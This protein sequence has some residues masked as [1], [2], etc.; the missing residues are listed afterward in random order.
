MYHRIQ[1]VSAVLIF[2]LF[3]SGCSGNKKKPASR[4]VTADASLAGNYLLDST[5]LGR[6]LQVYLRINEDNTF[7]WSNKLSGGDDKGQGTVGK[8]GDTYL[9]FYS[10]STNESPKTAT[11]TVQDGSLVFSTRVPYGASGFDPNTEDESNIIYPEAK[12]LAAGE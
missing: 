11:F 1:A 3:L 9:L 6:P 8:S 5:P 10:D 12:K 2:A 7:Q 4:P